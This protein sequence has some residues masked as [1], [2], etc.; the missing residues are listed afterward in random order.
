[1][2]TR[3]HLLCQVAAP[4]AFSFILAA[5]SFKTAL[6]F[7]CCINILFFLPEIILIRYLH[8]AVPHLQKDSK[9]PEEASP[10][11]S[12]VSQLVLG[13]KA[14]LQSRCFLLSVAFTLLFLTTLNPGPLLTAYLLTQ[15]INEVTIAFFQGAA[16]VFGI[17]PTFFNR[18]LFGCFGVSLT[19]VGSGWFQ[20]S[21]LIGS[22][23]FFFLPSMVQLPIISI[24]GE[25]Y[26]NWTVWPFLAFL[27]LSRVGLW[28]FDLS[29]RQIMQENVPEDQRGLINSTES[30][31][32]N[33]FLLMSYG[34]GMI[35]SQPSQFGWLV[36][37]SCSSVGLAAVCASLWLCISPKPTNSE[38]IKV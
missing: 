30:A 23:M 35:A 38:K 3:I 33:I 11:L 6:I 20:F 37:I 27:V 13:W 34:L 9:G 28:M 19:A 12:I 2:L 8:R 10:T 17:L 7:V 31:L 14:Y 29:E 21:C 25:N 24:W 16:A 36:G 1:M 5:T 32:S 22:A 18:I 26:A 4:V 15:G